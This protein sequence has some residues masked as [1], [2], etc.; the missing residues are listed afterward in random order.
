MNKPN[1][2]KRWMDEDQARATEL[3]L[4]LT[5][6]RRVGAFV[7]HD[8]LAILVLLAKRSTAY[9]DYPFAEA[10]GMKKVVEEALSLC[11]PVAHEYIENAMADYHAHVEAFV[12]EEKPRVVPTP[13][14]G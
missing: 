2:I 8:M 1:E 4:S 9:T 5:G 13:L 10:Q 12:N 7:P 14:H 3:L 6:N 11:D